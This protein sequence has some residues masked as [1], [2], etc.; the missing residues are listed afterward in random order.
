MLKSQHAGSFNTANDTFLP[1]CGAEV[2]FESR[3]CQSCKRALAFNPSTV[4]FEVLPQ[5]AALTEPGADKTLCQNGIDYGVCNWLAH[6]DAP[7]GLCSGCQYNRTI[8]NLSRT[9]NKAL[10]R[11]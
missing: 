11:Y 1:S 9:E 10:G 7:G 5:Q 2:F 8:P 4:S 6:K 3:I